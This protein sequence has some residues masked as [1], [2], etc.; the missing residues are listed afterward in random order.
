MGETPLVDQETFA[1]LV[2]KRRGEKSYCPTVTAN[3]RAEEGEHPQ[4]TSASYIPLGW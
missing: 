2:R 3:L 1:Q 4:L